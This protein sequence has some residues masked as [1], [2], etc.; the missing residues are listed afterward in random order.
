MRVH[1]S[2]ETDIEDFPGLPPHATPIARRFESAELL[3]EAGLKVVITVSPLLPIADPDRFFGRI[4]EVADSVVIDHFL[5]GD[6]SVNGARTKRTALPQAMRAVA[7][8]SI[9]LAYRQRMAE[10]AQRHLPGRVGICIDGFAG[11]FLEGP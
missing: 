3:K 8:E 5:G 6:G 9:D 4:A 10:V 11:R 2:I 1:I 7:P